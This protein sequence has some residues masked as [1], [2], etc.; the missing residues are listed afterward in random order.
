MLQTL[1]QVSRTVDLSLHFLFFFHFCCAALGRL[2][3]ACRLLSKVGSD[4]NSSFLLSSLSST[5][6][7]VVDDIIAGGEEEV[8][9]FTYVIVCQESLSRTCIHTPLQSEISR[10]E[11]TRF[12][13]QSLPGQEFNHVHFDSRHTEAAVMLAEY[14]TSS[15]AE[16][17]ITLS[18]DVEK[19]RPHLLSLILLCD[20]VFTNKAGIRDIF[21]SFTG[22]T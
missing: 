2:G 22:S 21:P 6:G 12:I 3:V 1:L 4:A 20:I 8:T 13:E 7:V 18:V 17:E 11:V 15:R 16:G 14:I 19:A 5:M 10:L 9:A